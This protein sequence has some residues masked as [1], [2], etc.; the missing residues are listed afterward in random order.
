M[1]TKKNRESIKGT[2][3]TKWDKHYAEFAS[4]GDCLEASPDDMS[5]AAASQFAARMNKLEEIKG[6]KRRFHS[7]FNVL[8]NVTF[9]RVRPDNEVTDKEEEQDKL[10]LE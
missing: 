5:R 6:G 8:E 1:F 4:P 10:E 7:G 2:Q 3:P 9:V